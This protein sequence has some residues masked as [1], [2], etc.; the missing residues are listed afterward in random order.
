MRVPTS[1]AAAVLA[2]APGLAQAA[3]PPCLT[4]AEFSSLAGYALP[5][6]INGT[7]KRCAQSLAPSA[8]LRS[9]GAGLASRY[10]ARKGPNWPGAKAA[11]LKLSADT[12]RDANQVLTSLPDESLQ[13]MLDAIL[14]GMVSQEIPLERCSTI[15]RFIRLLAPLPPE[16]T[17]ELIALTVGLASKSEKTSKV[18]KL[19]IC[20]S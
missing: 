19:Q 18:G 16:N 7:T 12:N 11:F 13:G 2:L 10:A 4:P 20:T 1:L 8:Y 15:D 3:Q 9:S 6:V 5:S 17:A 14:E